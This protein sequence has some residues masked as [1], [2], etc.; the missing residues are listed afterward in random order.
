MTAPPST[1]EPAS[2][3]GVPAADAAFRKRRWA[4]VLAD[5]DEW[6]RTALTRLFEPWRTLNTES[7]SGAMLAPYLLLAEPTNP[8]RYGDTGRLPAPLDI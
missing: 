1:P 2:S 6:H 3:S 8:R 5:A 4:Y 7:Y